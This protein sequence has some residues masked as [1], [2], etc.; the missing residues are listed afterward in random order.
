MSPWLVAA[1]AKRN[2]SKSIVPSLLASKV[3]NAYL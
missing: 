3:L 1:I 2:S